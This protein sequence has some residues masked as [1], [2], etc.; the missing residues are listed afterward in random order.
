MT[1]MT[2]ERTVHSG[3]RT[4]LVPAPA[5]H[6]TRRATRRP[7]TVEPVGSIVDTSPAT[8]PAVTHTPAALPAVAMRSETPAD[9]PRRSARRCGTRLLR[10]AGRH[11]P[12]SVTGGSAGLLAGRPR[13]SAGL[14]AGRPRD[15]AGPIGAPT[16][17]PGST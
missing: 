3:A 7:S 15:S 9:T 1:E 4:T 6:R 5:T 8:R 10:P 2:V 14:L 16:G 11:G 17:T 12:A 13:D